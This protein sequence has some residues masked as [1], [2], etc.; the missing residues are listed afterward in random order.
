MQVIIGGAYNGKGHY[1][2]EQLANKQAYFYD[3]EIP[4]A[5][6]SATDYVVIQ[7]VDKLLV[8]LKQLGEVTAAHTIAAQLRA[9]DAQTNVICICTDMSRGIVPLEAEARFLRDAC[10]RLYQQL[11]QQSEQVIRIWYGLAQQL[12]GELA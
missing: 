5:K 10:G 4:T 7:H 9:L 1:V 6:F 12:K 3:G 2:R 11:F 8:P